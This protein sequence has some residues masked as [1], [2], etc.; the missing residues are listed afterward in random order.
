MNNNTV[1][2]DIFKILLFTLNRFAPNDLIIAPQIIGGFLSTA[3]LIGLLVI[4]M[5][6]VM[7][8]DRAHLAGA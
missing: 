2:G 6:P 8:L 1:D 7:L 4:A 3:D 5:F